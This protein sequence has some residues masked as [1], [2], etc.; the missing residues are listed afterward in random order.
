M[1]NYVGA[2]KQV[3]LTAGAILTAG[4]VIVTESLVGIVQDG[5]ASGAQAI[6]EI[7]G[8]FRLAK[9]TGAIAAGVLVDWDTSA[10]KVDTGITPAAGDVEDFAVAVETVASGGTL[11]N[12]KLIPGGGTFA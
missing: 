8:V 1:K 12:V 9:A 6:L 4:Q 10:Q 7:E 11:I 5:V 2:G 3:Q